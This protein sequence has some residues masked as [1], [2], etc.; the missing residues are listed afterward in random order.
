M[1]T[2]NEQQQAKALR[3]LAEELD[4]PE[5]YYDKAKARYESL[6]AWLERDES[7]L[8]SLGPRIYAQ[9]SF[10]YGTVKPAKRAFD[11]DLVAEFTALSKQEQTQAWVKD[12]LGK[13]IKAYAEAHSMKAEPE[14]TKRCWNLE[15]AEE[16]GLEFH[17]DILP[18]VPEDETVKALLAGSVPHELAE[19]AIAF[20]DETDPAFRLISSEWPMSNP[21]GFAR[22]FESRMRG[23]ARQLLLERVEELPPHRWNTPLQKV[24]RILK[25]HRD[26]M[27]EH[28]PDHKPVSVIITTLAGQ[29]YEGQ[30]DLQ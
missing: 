29:A 24:V 16:G 26:T 1:A 20:T 9:G 25:D 12:A 23:A 13:E 17:M 21:R 5:S 15:Y 2:I 10:R 3:L 18:A 6:G 14:P 28:D 4:I 11:L 19:L 27:F 7:T 30:T 8:A 22:W